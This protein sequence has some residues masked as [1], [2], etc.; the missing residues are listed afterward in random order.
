MITMERKILLLGLLSQHEMHGYQLN[1]MIDTHIGT[2]LR[3]TKPTGYRVLQQMADDGWIKFREIQEGKRPSKRIYSI[4]SL[5]Q[6]QFHKLLRKS[7]SQYEPVENRNL[8]SLIFLDALPLNEVILLLKK[9]SSSL[10]KLILDTHKES[11]QHEHGHFG[12]LLENRTRHITTELEWLKEV[13][14]HLETAKTNET[15]KNR[16]ESKT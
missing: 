2:S 6:Q 10:E 15:E 12:F 16:M 7:L 14:S 3:L 1:E 13:I 9:R 4:T 5:G 8:I 11:E